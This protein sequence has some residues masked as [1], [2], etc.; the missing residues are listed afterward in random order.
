VI[1]LAV[2]LGALE[3]RTDKS[4]WRNARTGI[5]GTASYI[6]STVGSDA[7]L[8]FLIETG[9]QASEIEKVVV[10]QRSSDDVYDDATE[11]S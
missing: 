8:Q 10:G 6:A 5:T 1:S 3:A 7:Y 4:A 9:Y 2:V 11:Q